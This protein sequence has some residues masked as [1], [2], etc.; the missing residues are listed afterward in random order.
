MKNFNSIV[1]DRANLANRMAIKQSIDILAQQRMDDSRARKWEVS[2]EMIDEG[3]EIAGSGLL[4]IGMFKQLD[5]ALFSGALSKFY[6]RERMNMAIIA[7]DQSR[8]MLDREHRALYFPLDEVYSRISEFFH[9]EVDSVADFKTAAKAFK[10]TI[11]RKDPI[12]ENYDSA[13]NLLDKMMGCA[14]R[15]HGYRTFNMSPAEQTVVIDLAIGCAKA[16]V[17]KN[18]DESMMK[19]STEA[20]GT[21]YEKIKTAMTARSAVAAKRAKQQKQ[22]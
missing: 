15:S 6:A 17:V 19:I 20:M 4:D 16:L 10:S 7:F 12:I 5:K 8:Q 18:D 3:F 22:V 13:A 1:S 2:D 9:R 14:L 11:A 21:I